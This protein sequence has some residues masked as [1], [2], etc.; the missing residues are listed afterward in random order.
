MRTFAIGATC[1]TNSPTTLGSASR[2]AG[3]NP[4]DVALLSVLLE[5]HLREA[6]AR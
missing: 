4:P 3:V 1:R 2:I 6:A 5:R